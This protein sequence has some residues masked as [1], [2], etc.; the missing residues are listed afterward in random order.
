MPHSEA[1]SASA[2]QVLSALPIRPD[3]ASSQ[4]HFPL[5]TWCADALKGRVR[6]SRTPPLLGSPSGVQIPRE[7]TRNLCG[8]CFRLHPASSWW[9]LS[10]QSR[11]AECST[12]QR[13]HLE[14]LRGGHDEQVA[15]GFPRRTLMEQSK[16]GRDSDWKKVKDTWLKNRQIEGWNRLSTQQLINKP[17]RSFCPFVR[18]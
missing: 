15:K 7:E 5:S 3:F 9:Y 12:T 2:P 6:T 16:P 1:F 4:L 18:S 8:L 10:T 17:N 11:E 13:D 14:R